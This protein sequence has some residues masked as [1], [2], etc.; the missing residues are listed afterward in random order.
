MN[1]SKLIDSKFKEKYYKTIES[2]GNYKSAI[3]IVTIDSIK[4]A[5]LLDNSLLENSSYS[6]YFHSLA[7]FNRL[8]E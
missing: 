3:I 1:L 2:K 8:E 4:L 7:F 6:W 5:L